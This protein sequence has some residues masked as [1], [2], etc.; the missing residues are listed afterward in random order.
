M[1]DLGIGVELEHFEAH[2]GDRFAFREPDPSAAP[3]RVPTPTRTAAD[4]REF[5]IDGP[6]GI[7]GYVQ[8]GPEGVAA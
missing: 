4:L 2:L 8:D 7:H 5:D 6:D 3:D 1:E